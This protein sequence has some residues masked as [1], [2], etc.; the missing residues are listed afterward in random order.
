MRAFARINPSI[1]DRGACAGI[2]TYADEN[3]EV[4]VELLTR[5]SPNTWRFTNQPAVDKDG[6]LIEQASLAP[7]NLA[8]WT[9]WHEIRID[10]L[11]TTSN[12]YVDGSLVASNAYSVPRKASGLVL[13]MWS[14]GGLWTQ[15]MAIGS[16]AQLDVQW[17]EVVFDTYPAATSKTASGKKGHCSTVCTIDGVVQHGVPEVVA[18]ST[19]VSAANRY[20]HGLGYRLLPVTGIMLAVAIRGV[21]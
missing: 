16:T 8:G 13:N 17:V 11:P 2:F 10:W 12:W 4:D 3:N 5:D 7:N 20:G 6:N 15:E 1:K 18:D 14:D 9:D 21:F 19:P